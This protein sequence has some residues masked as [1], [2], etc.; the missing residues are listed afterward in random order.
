MYNTTGL[1]V[2][3]AWIRS[4]ALMAILTQKLTS[5]DS[6]NGCCKFKAVTATKAIGQKKSPAE[7]AGL[8]V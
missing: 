6:S 7:T 4:I 5:P 3:W 8:L 2:N 1:P